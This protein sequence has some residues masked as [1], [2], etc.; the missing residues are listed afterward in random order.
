MD[1]LDS[2]HNSTL[3]RNLALSRTNFA[4]LLL[5]YSSDNL[6]FLNGN[7][8]S[9][10]SI[11]DIVYDIIDQ[12]ELSG[13]WIMFLN[14]HSATTVFTETV[15]HIKINFNIKTKIEQ[16]GYSQKVKECALKLLKEITEYQL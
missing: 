3:L 4:S 16:T 14:S 11:K 7:M 13:L 10:R 2:I 5:K 1:T 9:L 6:E 15:S 12:R 8:R